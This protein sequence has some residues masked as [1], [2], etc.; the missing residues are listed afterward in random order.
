MFT[1]AN[2]ANTV[3]VSDTDTPNLLASDEACFI[4]SIICSMDVWDSAAALAVWSAACATSLSAREKAERKPA[5]NSAERSVSTSATR[6]RFN[7]VGSIAKASLVF[8]PAWAKI[9]RAEASC[10]GP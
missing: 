10:T 9:R 7:V 5:R 2:S 6:E 8:R 1:R 3:E 4:D